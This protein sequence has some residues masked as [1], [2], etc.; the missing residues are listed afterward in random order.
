MRLSA[1]KRERLKQIGAE[2]QEILGGC[3]HP[4]GRPMTFSELEDECVEAGDPLTA[5]VIERRVAQREAPQDGCGCPRCQRPGTRLPEDEV[6]VL[7]TDRGEVAWMEP[8]F[9]C[10]DCR[11]SFFPSLG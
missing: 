7:Q 9:H 1:S 8:T 5:G 10:R 6:R 11:R 3:V 2:V 4:D